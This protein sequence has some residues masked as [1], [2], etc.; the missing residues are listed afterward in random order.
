MVAVEIHR[1]REVAFDLASNAY[2]SGALTS[3]SLQGIRRAID[4]ESGATKAKPRF[5]PAECGPIVLTLSQGIYQPMRVVGSR[6]DLR[7]LLAYPQE[8]PGRVSAVEELDPRGMVELMPGSGKRP[9]SASAARKAGR[10]YGATVLPE[11]H[12]EFGRSLEEALAKHKRLR[13]MASPTSMEIQLLNGNRFSVG[14]VIGSIPPYEGHGVGSAGPFIKGFGVTA[15]RLDDGR[16]EVQGHVQGAVGRKNPITSAAMAIAVMAAVSA[17]SNLR[18]IGAVTN[19]GVE[20][21]VI[22]IGGEPILTASDFLPYAAALTSG[23]D[24]GEALARPIVRGRM[25]LPGGM[26]KASHEVHPPMPAILAATREIGSRH[27][28]AEAARLKLLGFADDAP[29]MTFAER[30]S[31]IA[32][33]PE[34]ARDATGD[35][36]RPQGARR[37][38]R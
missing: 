11:A 22:R 8:R 25:E 5:A 37:W 10:A 15:R 6:R 1:G 13:A 30:D 4:A 14:D 12:P 32:S 3:P 28:E 19:L 24:T 29:V 26:A 9:L 27:A 36:S 16:W 17:R 20:T 33:L 38:R 35:D 2:V 18:P 31:L 23:S 34:A 7:L 21:Q